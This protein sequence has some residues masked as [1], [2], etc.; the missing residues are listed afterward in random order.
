MS[1]QER[2]HLRKLE[3]QAQGSRGSHDPEEGQGGRTKAEEK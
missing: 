3:S 1:G 2:R